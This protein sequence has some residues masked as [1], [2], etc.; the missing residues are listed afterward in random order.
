MAVVEEP[1]TD[2]ASA[3]RA[4]TTVAGEVT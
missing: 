3:A 2:L 4:G 1:P